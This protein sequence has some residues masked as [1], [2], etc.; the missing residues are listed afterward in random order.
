MTFTEFNELGKVIDIFSDE[1]VKVKP[2][3]IY[4]VYS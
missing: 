3:G 2:L 1:V 4:S